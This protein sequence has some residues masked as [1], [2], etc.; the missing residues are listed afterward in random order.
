LK[1]TFDLTSDLKDRIEEGMKQDGYGVK[2]KS[3]WI[4]EA[5]IALHRHDPTYARVGLGEGLEKFNTKMG[6]TLTA[7]AAEEIK[8]AKSIIRREDPESEGLAGQIIRAS[9]RSRLLQSGDRTGLQIPSKP[10]RAKG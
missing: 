10:K 9:I 2:Q 1:T 7:V 3:A 4:C 6:V 5:I 8:K